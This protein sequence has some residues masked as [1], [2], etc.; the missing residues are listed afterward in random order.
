MQLFFHK[1]FASKT[2]QQDDKVK[3]NKKRKS[4]KGADDSSD[5]ESIGD[6]GMSDKED[7]AEFEMSMN[8]KDDD[9]EEDSEAEDAI[10]KAMKASMPKRAGDDEMSGD[11]ED[12]DSDI[13]QFNYSDSDEEAEA[14]IE[15][16]DEPFKSAFGQE[17]DDA[18]DGSDG[19]NL[20]EDEDDLIGSD[21][22][23]PMFAGDGGDEGQGSEA[24]EKATS[25]SQ[26]RRKKKRKLNSLPMFATAEDYAHLLGD[27][28]GDD[29]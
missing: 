24:D 7:D 18:D 6:L 11:E 1:Y 25:K 13:E 15:I 10:W 27:D 19:D 23:M 26:E 28:D 22:D 20:M 14:T 12:D 2:P 8:A 16:A 9:E 4:R 5:E 29:I 21:E 17:E 3:A